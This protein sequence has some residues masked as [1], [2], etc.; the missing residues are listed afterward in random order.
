M[1]RS[2]KRIALAIALALGA[3]S[4]VAAVT[5]V[6]AVP[7]AE[8]R[9]PVQQKA[10]P[11]SLLR[12]ADAPAARIVLAAP[13]ASER[14]SL[15]ALNAAPSHSGAKRAAQSAKGPLAVGFGRVVPAA[16]R[17]VALASLDW[18]AQADGSRVAHVVVQ[19]PGAVALRVALALPS[20]APGLTVSFATADGATVHAPVPAADVTADGAQHLAYWS[21]VLEGDTAVIELRATPSLALDGVTLTIPAVSHQVVAPAHLRSLTPKD[22]SDIGRSGACE[23]DVKCVS[24]QSTALNNA[25]N[26]VAKMIFT[27][28]NGNSYLCTGQLLN[29][30]AATFTPWFFSANHCINSATA[31]RTINTYWFFDALSCATPRD[32]RTP[33]YIQQTAGA[34]L[35]ARSPDYDWALMRL[36]T[37]PP[38]GTYLYAWRSD[39]LPTGSEISVIHHPAGDLKKWA[40]GNMPG[41]QS[42]D[43]GSTFWMARYTQGTTEGGSSGAALV[44]FNGAGGY[45]EVRGGLYGGD[46]SC[47]SLAGI[48]EYSQIGTMLPRVREYLTPGNNP[49]S[50]VVAVEFYNRGLDHYFISTNPDEIANLDSGRTRGWERTGIRFNAYPTQVPGTNPVCRFYRVPAFGDS[51]FYSADPVECANTAAAHPVDWFYESASVFYLFL[52]NTVNGTCPANTQR[53]WRFFNQRTTNH[54]YTNEV[55]LHDEMLSNPATWIPEGYGVDGPV[56][57][58]PIGA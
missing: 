4:A 39:P 23:I 45:Y 47:Q 53:V 2:L 48:D 30:S 24:P 27:Q 21:P 44:T 18:Q 58:A 42:Y 6:T 17:D 54:R 41:V 56:M 46:A 12:A 43:D 7:P 38:V 57:C 33:A 11:A 35:L 10:A 51:H 50:T 19:S 8:F 14:A 13:S 52:P 31:A 28:E 40:A 22:A 55:A 16:S 20:I 15:K 36:N 49:A 9:P 32:Q 37:A 3:T 34:A 29:D 5:P 1:S 26:A 25:S